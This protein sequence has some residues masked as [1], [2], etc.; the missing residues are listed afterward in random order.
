MVTRG[1][2]GRNI[3]KSFENRFLEIRF[4][5]TTSYLISSVFPTFGG[6][7][8]IGREDSSDQLVFSLKTLLHFYEISQLDRTSILRAR[9]KNLY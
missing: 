5:R 9:N 6:K 1:G 7:K 2:Q 4:F 8:G 3:K